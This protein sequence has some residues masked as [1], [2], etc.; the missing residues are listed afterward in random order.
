MDT[1]EPVLSNDFVCEARDSILGI[2]RDVDSVPESELTTVLL[3]ECALLFAY[4]GQTQQFSEWGHK[5]EHYLNRAIDSVSAGSLGWR[6]GLYGGLAEVG[7]VVQHVLELQDDSHDQQSADPMFKD[8]QEGDDPLTDIDDLILRRL[9]AAWG[10]AGYD[11]ISGHVGLGVYFL[12]R[13]PSASALRGMRL[14]LERLEREAEHFPQGLTWHTGPGL[15]PPD[16][17]EACPNGYYNLGVAHGV[18]G[19]LYLLAECVA[20]EIMGINR[21]STM[22]DAAVSWLLA[23]ERPRR[24]FT[25]F[26]PWIAP[27]IE[28]GDARLGWC[29][30][31]LGIGAVLC[32]IAQRVGRK[33][34]FEY[35]KKILD[36]CVDFPPHSSAINDAML[37]HGAIGVAHVFNR[38][39]Q[40]TGRPQYKDAAVFWFKRG[41]DMRVSGR[42]IGG[43]FAYKPDQK[44]TIWAAD[45]T[46]LSG[47]IGIALA[48]LSAVSNLEPKWDRIMLLSDSHH[49]FGQDIRADQESI[50][51]NCIE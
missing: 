43:F 26:S 29:Y 4:L 27:G 49:P 30:G 46:F 45:P 20:L 24:A 11:L 47:S 51:L 8:Q 23:Q 34:W 14:I 9:E 7:W 37:C 19:V 18:P 50:D 36:R 17:R 35:A 10:A 48:L 13:L 33:D 40:A 2:A 31:D 21:A 42:G 25:R 1:W 22:L 6:L 38:A 39:Y 41:L 15:L 3:C 5:T 28:T 44:P 12:Q 16:Q 32:Q